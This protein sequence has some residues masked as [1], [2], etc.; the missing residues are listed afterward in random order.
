[1]RRI[2][3]L[4]AAVLLALSACANNPGNGTG[5]PTTPTETTPAPE[6]AEC[7][8]DEVGYV[9]RY[10]ADW[11]TNPGDVVQTCSYFDPEPISVTEGT[12]PDVAVVLRSTDVGYR[13]TSSSDAFGEVRSRDSAMVDGREA[14]AVV[15]EATG[16]GLLDEGTLAYTWVVDIADGSFLATTHDAPGRD[17]S[18]NSRVVDQIMAN[19]DFTAPPPDDGNGDNG[20]DGQDGDDGGPPGERTV[21]A[22]YD[23]FD[24]VAVRTAEEVCLVARADGRGGDPACWSAGGSDRE[25]TVS[26]LDVPGDLRAIGG[27]AA[28]ELPRVLVATTDE[29]TAGFRPSP[30]AGT[31]TRAWVVPVDQSATDRVI[32]YTADQEMAVAIDARGRSTD[33]LPGTDTQPENTGPSDQF[34]LLTDVETGLHAGYDR[35]TFQFGDGAPGY[36]VSYEDRPITED[37]SGAEVSIQGDAVVVVRMRLASGRERTGTGEPTYTGPERLRGAGTFAVTEV[38]RTGDFEGVLS[39]A[40]GVR[41]ESPIRVQVFGNVIAVDVRHAESDQGSAVG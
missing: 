39:W 32:G 41:G 30:V 24:V 28:P 6:L 34:H 15:D 5:G 33:V 35:V 25:L 11:H 31:D 9:A 10:P 23:G 19:L 21:V 27:L 40:V 18:R 8:N 7:T 14:V 20:Q 17:F 37:G 29:G 3:P 22:R 13:T 4:S 2:W 12:E 36:E 1:M 26:P 38:V 16:E